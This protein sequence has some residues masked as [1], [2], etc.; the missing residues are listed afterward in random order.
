MADHLR[1]GEVGDWRQHCE[2]HPELLEAFEA[3][4]AQEMRGCA[5][6]RWDCGGGK[7]MAV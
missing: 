1:K 2:P 3:A 5:G 4:F 6:R 7:V